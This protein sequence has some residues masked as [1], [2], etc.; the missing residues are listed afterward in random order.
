MQVC[1]GISRGEEAVEVAVFAALGTHPLRCLSAPE[2]G[3]PFLPRAHVEGGMT[4]E[5]GQSDVGEVPLPAFEEDVSWLENGA[6][7]L[8]LLQGDE[9]LALAE[10]LDLAHPL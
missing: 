5:S 3:P 9:G 10:K 7:T 4:P 2:K 8:D 6:G 1:F